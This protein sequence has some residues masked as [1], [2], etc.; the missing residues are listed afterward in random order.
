VDGRSYSAQL[1]VELEGIDPHDSQVIYVNGTGYVADAGTDA[2]LAYPDYDTVPPVNPFIEFDATEWQ[3][4]GPDP[5]TGDLIRFHSTTW[6]LPSDSA[7][8]P[9]LSAVSFDL[10]LDATGLPLSGELSFQLAGTPGSA[11]AGYTASYEF[12]KMGEPVRIVAPIQ[13]PS[14]APSPSASPTRSP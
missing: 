4:M 7:S 11:A 12:S 5:N 6:R 13:Q 3:D 1:H 8:A 10:W 2:W 9:R 14:V